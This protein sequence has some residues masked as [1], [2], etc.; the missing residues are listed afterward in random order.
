MFVLSSIQL[1]QNDI[2]DILDIVTCYKYYNIVC[3][4]VSYDLSF[5]SPI[6]LYTYFILIVIHVDD[7]T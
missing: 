3:G 1:N 7:G 2:L 5:P 4:M 6:K